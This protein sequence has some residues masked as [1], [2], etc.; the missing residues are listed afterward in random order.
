MRI[1]DNGGQGSYIYRHKRKYILTH[2]RMHAQFRAKGHVRY[3]T[4][5][6]P[7]LSDLQYVIR[8]T[9]ARHQGIGAEDAKCNSGEGK[10]LNS[11][12]AHTHTHAYA[13][14]RTL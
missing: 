14:Y 13:R 9:R 10:C 8:K 2:I 1:F 11:T 12:P 5:G 3:P 7:L 6:A 4:R